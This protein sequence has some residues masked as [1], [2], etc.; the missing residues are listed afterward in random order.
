MRPTRLSLFGSLLLGAVLV[1]P[2]AGAAKK[3]ADSDITHWVKDALM[4][5]ERVDPARV[6]VTVRDGIV[7]LAGDVES[8]AAKQYA[9]MEAKKIKGVRGVVDEIVVAPTLRSDT[10]ICLSVRH[11]LLT[12][13][14]VRSDDIT[15]TCLDGEVTLH[16]EVDSWSERQEASLLASEV[17]GVKAVTNEISSHWENDRSDS[18]IQ[19]DAL[20]AMVRDVYL[21]ELPIEVTVKDGVVTLKGS[22]DC[23]YE[24]DRA[25]R[26][27]RWVPNV[28]GVDDQLKVAWWP[29]EPEVARKK[30][31]PSD[32]ELERTVRE[33]LQQDARL[34]AG[35]IDI[36]ANQGLVVLDGLVDTAYERRVAEQDARNVVGVGWVTNNLFP[37]SDKREDSLI[38]DD[39]AF[40]L[41]TDYLLDDFDITTNVIDGVV[42]LSGEVHSAFEKLH[43]TELASKVRGVK[44]VVNLIKV[45]RSVWKDDATLTREVQ[46][47]IKWNAVTRSVAYRIN[48]TVNNG[49]ATL[50]GDVDTWA[51]RSEA[52]RVVLKTTGIWKLD[53]RLA[54][55]GYDYPWDEWHYRGSYNYDQLALPNGGLYDDIPVPW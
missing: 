46:N 28:K 26:D 7:T 9:N 14:V 45:P 2:A 29:L 38:L 49:V 1:A 51:E 21:S 16:G 12:S 35:D 41:E 55:N 34:E 37:A 3:V 5:D 33:A 13:S 23:A 44:S 42:T 18:E 30:P 47:R 15:A 43:A 39:V 48:V 4:H 25:R 6:G 32:S 17:R 19:R 40:N 50:V 10:D 8:I 27:V 54:V 31:M 36:R 53:N 11:R 20:A 22:V 52:G 24:K